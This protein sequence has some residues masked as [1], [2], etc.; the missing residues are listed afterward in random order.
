VWRTSICRATAQWLPAGREIGHTRSD[1]MPALHLAAA[2]D[3]EEALPT[4]RTPHRA[5]WSEGERS[6]GVCAG[7]AMAAGLDHSSPAE[8]TLTAMN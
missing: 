3:E 2:R 4:A 1:D 8:R 5:K 6:Y 7:V